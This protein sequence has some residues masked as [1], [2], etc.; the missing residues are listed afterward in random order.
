MEI[1]RLG[2]DCGIIIICCGTLLGTSSEIR[3]IY[4]GFICITGQH[5]G[6]G[7]PALRGYYDFQYVGFWTQHT[8]GPGHIRDALRQPPFW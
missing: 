5:A 1:P 7:V 3:V 4:R 2:E 8:S 6:G